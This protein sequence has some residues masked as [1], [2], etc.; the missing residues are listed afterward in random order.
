MMA[1]SCKAVSA[2]QIINIHDGQQLKAV[3]VIPL[4]MYNVHAH[5]ICTF[6]IVILIN[7]MFYT[8]EL[9]Q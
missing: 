6:V 4:H 9:L 5:G 8:E 1:N 3:M 2:I 7:K